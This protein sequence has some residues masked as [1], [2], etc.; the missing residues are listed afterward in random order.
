MSD[1]AM[2]ACLTVKYVT[3]HEERGAV[4]GRWLCT[5]CN[6]QFIAQGAHLYLRDEAVRKALKAVCVKKPEAG[7]MSGELEEKV[8]EEA[9][10][11]DV[12]AKELGDPGTRHTG[13]R[14]SHPEFKPVPAQ[15][16]K[17]VD[18]STS[19]TEGDLPA[20]SAATIRAEVNFEECSFCHHE[21]PRPVGNHHTEEE[22]AANVAQKPPTNDLPK[23][24]KMALWQP[25]PQADGTTIFQCTVDGFGLRATQSSRS[26]QKALAYCLEDLARQMIEA[27]HG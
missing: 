4:S 12:K 16:H 15:V 21:F 5:L 7:P 14:P 8:L 20:P 18:P 25:L 27:D 23:G 17:F 24:I 11:H 2:C 22:C 10:K 13:P 6:N 1:G 19:P 3:Q 9:L 26:K